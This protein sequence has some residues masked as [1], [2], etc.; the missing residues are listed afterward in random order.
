M[1][2][3][4]MIFNILYNKNKVYWNNTRIKY[5]NQLK[6]YKLLIKNIQIINKLYYN[7]KI[8]YFSI[9]NVLMNFNLRLQQR[10]TKRKIINQKF[11]N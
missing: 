11:K 2:S 5:I 6:I 9:K 7:Q 10:M 8:I 1:D 3:L 4:E